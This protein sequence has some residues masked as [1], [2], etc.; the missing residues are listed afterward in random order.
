V[1][2]F[3]VK[4]GMNI[5][6]QAQAFNL[7]NHAQYVPGFLNQVNLLGFTGSG[8]AQFVRANNSQFANLANAF[9]NQPRTMQL[10]A[11]FTF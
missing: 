4:E 2:R 10:V 1:K 3:T 9:S 7:F 6:I 5:E 11:K 8:A